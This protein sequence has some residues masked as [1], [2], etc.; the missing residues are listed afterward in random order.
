MNLAKKSYLIDEQPAF[1]FRL[2]CDDINGYIRITK[3]KSTK[4]KKTRITERNVPIDI[5]T[6]D[7]FYY[8]RTGWFDSKMGDPFTGSYVSKDKDLNIY[9]YWEKYI[10]QLYLNLKKRQEELNKL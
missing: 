10:N 2:E 5:S 9:L 7:K 6:K 3:Y 4:S 8:N 1:K